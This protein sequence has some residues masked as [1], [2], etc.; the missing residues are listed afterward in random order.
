MRDS[1]AALASR[2]AIMHAFRSVLSVCS[3]SAHL[4]PERA[5]LRASKRI[6]TSTDCL[7]DLAIV[8]L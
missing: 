2:P 5:L 4:P 3:V 8:L 1:V 7:L 6:G